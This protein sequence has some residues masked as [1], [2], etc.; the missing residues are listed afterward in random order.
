MIELL[1]NVNWY[2]VFY[3]MTVA[4]NVKMVTGILSIAL[5][6]YIFIGFLAALGVGDSPWSDWERASRKAYLIVLIPFFI[7]IFSW[8]LVPSKR[9]MMVIVAGGS[10][11]NFVSS[12]SS[13][14]AIPAELT[15]YVRNY[16]KK[17]ADDVDS[18]LKQELNLETPKDKLI[19]NV[20][21][22][23]K[24]QIIEYLKTDTSLTK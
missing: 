16:L 2:K 21:D 8:M 11:G 24:E 12:D 6:I 20:K 14:R 9:D 7:S 4:D 19:R 3:W 18:D 10:I 17:E 23:T 13:S 1:L 15:R 22:M 5:G